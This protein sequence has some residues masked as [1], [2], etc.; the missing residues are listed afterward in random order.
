M[1]EFSFFDIMLIVLGASL[2]L[3]DLYTVCH[4]GELIMK[5]KE[6]RG[7]IIFYIVGLIIVCMMFWHNVRDYFYYGKSNR[8]N[9]INNILGII[10]LIEVSISTIIKT[11]IN[12]QIRENGIY[13]FGY[14]YKWSKIQSYSL[15]SPNR[16]EFKV[17]TLFKTNK[18]F[19]LNIN[20]EVKFKVDEVIQRNLSS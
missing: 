1:N 18:S 6:D 20:E 13:Y 2:L 9:N 15:V 5:V 14:F 16:I 19:K 4:H 10:F 12:S 7:L 17:N 3:K 11:F 8:I